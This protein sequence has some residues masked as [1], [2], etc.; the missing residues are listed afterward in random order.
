MWFYGVLIGSN[1]A[2]SRH[3]DDNTNTGAVEMLGTNQ[4]TEW[5]CIK[6]D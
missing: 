6:L 2:Y 4:T 5:V 3:A 1:M